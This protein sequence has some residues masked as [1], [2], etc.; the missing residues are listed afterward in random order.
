MQSSGRMRTH[1]AIQNHLLNQG[2]RGPWPSL[3]P[4]T[5]PFSHGKAITM[6][7]LGQKHVIHEDGGLQT[8]DWV[9]AQRRQPAEARSG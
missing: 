1:Y 5:H 6:L 9:D 4:S 7:F 2:K 3:L 8:Q